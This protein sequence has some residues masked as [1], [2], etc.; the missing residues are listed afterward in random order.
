MTSHHEQQL[1]GGEKG[2][3]I[4]CETTAQVNCD[5]VNTSVYSE[6]LS[7]P[8]ATW[9]FATYAVL[10]LGVLLTLSGKKDYLKPIFFAGIGSVLY[11][12]FLYYISMVELGFVCLWC[13]R[14]YAVNLAIPILTGLAGALR[15][16]FGFQALQR[17]ALLSQEPLHYPLVPNKSTETAFWEML[18]VLIWTRK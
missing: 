15:F 10:L 6:F 12:G 16:S 17:Y 7:I 18:P 3:L 5:V 4:G 14:L 2:K 11:S 1:Y 9:G 8:I 13:M